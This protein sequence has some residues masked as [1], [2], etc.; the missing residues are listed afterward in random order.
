MKENKLE[1]KLKERFITINNQDTAL[2]KTLFDAKSFSKDGTD[3]LELHY[4]TNSPEI[5][6]ND[7]EEIY[8]N[9]QNQKIK[10]IDVS[11][12][13]DEKVVALYGKFNSTIKQI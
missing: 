12:S 4:K 3:Y 5:I 10:N 6:Q 2:D 13:Y 9:L 8:L 1:V 11:P 7:A